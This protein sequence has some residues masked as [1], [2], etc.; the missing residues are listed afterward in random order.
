MNAS[1][2]VQLPTELCQKDRQRGELVL[3]VLGDDVVRRNARA[4]DGAKS[5]SGS[6]LSATAV[7]EL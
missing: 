2:R 1:K 5:V 4:A 6:G 7:R 3:E